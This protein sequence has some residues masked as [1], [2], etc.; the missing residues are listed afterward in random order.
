MS[1]VGTLKGKVEGLEEEKR[2]LKEQLSQQER[3]LQQV[4]SEKEKE[5]LR[6]EQ[7]RREG[8]KDREYMTH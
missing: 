1:E 2:S 6:L 7:A 8:Q 3:Q 4:V 5:E